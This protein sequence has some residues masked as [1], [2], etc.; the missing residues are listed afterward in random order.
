MKNSALA[1]SV[2][3]W[4]SHAS[5]VSYPYHVPVVQS[6][7][8]AADKSSKTKINPKMPQQY[9]DDASSRGGFSVPRCIDRKMI[10]G[11]PVDGDSDVLPVVVF[12]G[13]GVE[14]I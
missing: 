2:F 4:L 1:S 14:T 5:H 7:V 8:D 10:L 11:W 9:H 6:V 13:V 12:G 3:V